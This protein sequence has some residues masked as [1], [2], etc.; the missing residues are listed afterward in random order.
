[1]RAVRVAGY[2]GIAMRLFLSRDGRTLF[3]D[4]SSHLAKG[5]LGADEALLYFHRK[6]AAGFRI[7]VVPTPVP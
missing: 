1:M 3:L 5:A 4:D 2:G 6:E 7:G